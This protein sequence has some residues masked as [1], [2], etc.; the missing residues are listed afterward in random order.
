MLYLKR[1]IPNNLRLTLLQII[2]FLF[3]FQCTKDSLHNPNSPQTRTRIDASAFFD[4]GN[5]RFDQRYMQEYLDYVN[6]ALAKR[7]ITEPIKFSSLDVDIFVV[8]SGRLSVNYAE[9]FP[10]YPGVSFCNGWN[11]N[12]AREE[13]APPGTYF[14]YSLLKS[15]YEGWHA[16]SINPMLSQ[17]G[18]WVKSAR[19]CRIRAP[20]PTKPRSGHESIRYSGPPSPPT[21][22]GQYCIDAESKDLRIS[23][24]DS[25]SGVDRS[26]LLNP[27]LTNSEI[28]RILNPVTSQNANSAN[29]TTFREIDDWVYTEGDY[30]LEIDTENEDWQY[31]CPQSETYTR[32]VGSS[33]LRFINS[34]S[35]RFRILWHY[36][37]EG[38]IY[39]IA[40]FGLLINRMN[41]DA[42]RNLIGHEIGHNHG[43]P[44][45]S[46]SE[47][48]PCS[49]ARDPNRV[50]FT[51]IFDISFRFNGCEVPI[52]QVNL[53]CYNLGG[54]C[55]RAGSQ[56]IRYE[57]PP[58]EL[59]SQGR[60][61]IADWQSYQN[62]NGTPINAN[63]QESCDYKIAIDVAQEQK[64]F[65]TIFPES[66]KHGM[67]CR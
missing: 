18:S 32:L 19:I 41:G 48:L 66:E 40:R 49:F 22:A 26:S 61:H 28:N 37:E 38:I 60:T 50:M 51:P 59:L 11:R 39:S 1:N 63:R 34:P 16:A 4:S 43:L 7:S 45:V 31:G 12:F 35:D 24:N 23:F 33:T 17:L 67:G 29:T 20:W 2:L 3:I 9:L 47:G 42:T 65:P 55:T 62:L 27:P 54:N 13:V 21:T 46:Q 6:F 36:P 10:H 25:E 57:N 64:G 15:M 8:T 52:G 5:D 58:L 14:D 44:H 53:D 30:R 56:T